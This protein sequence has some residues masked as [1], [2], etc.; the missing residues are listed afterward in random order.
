MAC[1]AAVAWADYCAALADQ[2]G[3]AVANALRAWMVLSHLPVDVEIA[4]RR[5]RERHKTA[6][7]RWAEMHWPVVVIDRSAPVLLP[8]EHIIRRQGLSRFGKPE[9]DR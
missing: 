5:A 1:A 4:G 2:S 3:W 8:G 6:A 7:E 9:E